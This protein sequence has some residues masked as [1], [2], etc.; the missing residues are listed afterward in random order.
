MNMNE[1]AGEGKKEGRGYV[2]ISPFGVTFQGR[3]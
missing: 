3:C 1:Q 2:R